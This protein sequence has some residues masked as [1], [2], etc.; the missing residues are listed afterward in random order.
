[1]MV[2]PKFLN[3]VEWDELIYPG[4]EVIRSYDDFRVY[5][6]WMS[7]KMVEVP[8]ALFGAEMGLGKTASALKAI[9]TLLDSGET[10]HWLIVAPLRVAELTWPEEIATWD[11]ARDIPYRVVTGTEAERKAALRLKGRKITIINRENLRWLLEMHGPKGWPYEG[12]VYDEASRLKA[13]RMRGQPKVDPETG[14]VIRKGRL[15][16]FGVINRVRGLTRRVIE[17]SGTPTPNGLIDLYGPIY[18]IDKGDRL[19]T[20][21]TQFEDRWFSF[22]KYTYEKKIREGAEGEIMDR[23]GDVF[24]SLKEADYL[25]LPPMVIR[26]HKVRLSNKEMDTYHEMQREFAIEVVNR[27]DEPE[28]IEAV[29]NGVLCGKLLQLANGSIYSE[30]GSAVPFHDHKLKVLEG[31]FAEAMGKPV[32]VAYSFQFDRDA[33]LKKFGKKA[34]LF[35]GSTQMMRDWNAG[36]IPMMV[37][38]PASAGHGLNFQRGGNI[39]V[40]YGLTWSLELYLQFIKRLH[41][42]GQ[43][44]SHV[45]LHRI[46]AAGTADYD[47]LDKLTEKGATQSRIMDAVRVILE[48]AA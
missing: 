31:I 14:E 34:K 40:W 18:V 48:A 43:K 12:L 38:H 45:F 21:K 7:D 46:L 19:G 5:Q 22:N 11:F 3:S 29:N 26:D 15:T 27:W 28:V 25:D 6:R 2:H 8:A 16:G 10:R 1:M 44:E 37:M 41:R 23:V 33:I 24:F 36:K 13:A 35:D 17:L 20:S 32:L 47:V 42:S 4:P 39:A 9:R 30:D